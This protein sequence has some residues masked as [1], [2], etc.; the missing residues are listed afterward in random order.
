MKKLLLGMLLLALYQPAGAETYKCAVGGKVL[1]TNQ[2]PDASSKCTAVFARKQPTGE[3]VAAAPAD[4]AKDSKE[5]SGNNATNGKAQ[6]KT[7]ADK[8]LED[9]L[10]KPG[11]EDARK[12]TEENQ[13]SQK[14]KVQNCQSAKQNLATLKMGR[15]ARM[16]EK[17]EKYYLDDA[18]IAQELEQANKDAERW[19]GD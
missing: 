11:A 2:T 5:G 3:P 4:S 1:Y 9:K 14:I 7:K 12:K 18:A 10:K 13:T 17:G 19:C 8:E 16:N 6:A 15:V